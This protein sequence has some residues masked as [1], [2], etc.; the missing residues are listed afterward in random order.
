MLMQRKYDHSIVH[1]V[2]AWWQNLVARLA[3]KEKERAQLRHRHEELSQQLRRK[4]IGAVDFST[5]EAGVG[6]FL[7]HSM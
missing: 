4:T 1:F 2:S 7:P 5:V 3:S 6:H